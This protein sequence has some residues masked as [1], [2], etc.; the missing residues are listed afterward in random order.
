MW[1]VAL[2]ER[3]VDLIASKRPLVGGSLA[4]RCVPSYDRYDWHDR[5]RGRG[6][7]LGTFGHRRGGISS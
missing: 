2:G 4:I 6:A 5:A 7:G 1:G 3:M